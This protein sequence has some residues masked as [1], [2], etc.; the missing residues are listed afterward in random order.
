MKSIIAFFLFLLCLPVWA[1]P[2]KSRSKTVK[3]FDS[4]VSGLV[5]AQIQQIVLGG[6]ITLTDSITFPRGKTIIPN[7][8]HFKEGVK[9][10]TVIFDSY[11]EAGRTKV[12][13]DFEPGDIRGSFT[14]V[15]PEWWGLT[16]SSYDDGQHDIAINSAISTFKPGIYGN[17]VSLSSGIY[18]V[19][20]PIDLRG[21]L[22]RLVGAGSGA[23]K[24]YATK[25]WEPSKWDDCNFWANWNLSELDT[26]MESGPESHSA[27]VWIGAEKNSPTA[28]SFFTGVS[29]LSL[30]GYFP[31]RK[32]PNKRISGISWTGY[33]EELSSIRD[34]GI[35]TFSGFGI[36]GSHPSNITTVNGLTISNFFLADATRRG[37]VGVFA[38]PHAGVMAIRDGTMDFR[39]GRDE[40][41]IGN[42]VY[43]KTWPQFG[44]LAAGAHTAIDNIHF[45]GTGNAIHVYS[46]AGAGGASISNCDLIHGMDGAMRFYDDFENRVNDQPAQIGQDIVSD[47]EQSFIFRYSCLVSLGRS[48]GEYS[49]ALNYNSTVT[50]SNICTL[51]QTVYLLRDWAYGVHIYGNGNFRFP[52]EG[53]NRI[54]AYQ[55]GIPYGPPAG[56]F[57]RQT[58]GAFYYPSKPLTDREYF[59][60]T[61]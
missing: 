30:S 13:H 8:W 40:S 10:V 1:A 29:G 21:S 45:E 7:S 41:V 25:T 55:R 17:T 27:L 44:I 37:A 2:A 51:D 56:D 43:K 16:G 59:K 46:W 61:R 32:F 57:P 34:V 5:D 58:P 60:I 4:L 22:S 26:Q 38:P 31:V 28:Q 11:L 50:I 9:D 15:F 54:A 12:F 53:G 39:I 42:S 49:A 33:L 52:N 14:E 47:P 19:S 35:T 48:P 6:D 24:I 18:Y 3:S 23:T 36:G 20:K